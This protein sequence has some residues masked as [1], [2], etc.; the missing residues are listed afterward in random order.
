MCLINLLRCDEETVRSIKY[1]LLRQVIAVMETLCKK[2]KQHITGFVHAMEFRKNYGILKRKFHVWKNYGI[3]VLVGK[4]VCAFF[5]KIGGEY[6][7]TSTRGFNVCCFSYHFT[8]PSS[9]NL[10]GYS[11]SLDKVNTC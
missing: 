5:K 1:L 11:A 4:K 3:F 9:T 10:P 6:V 8:R 7:R 2:K